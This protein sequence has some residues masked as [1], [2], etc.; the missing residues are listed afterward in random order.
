[1]EGVAFRVCEKCSR[2]TIAW[3]L[4]SRDTP[5]TKCSCCNLQ[6]E[7]TTDNNTSLQRYNLLVGYKEL[8][9]SRGRKIVNDRVEAQNL[10][11]SKPDLPKEIV[12]LAGG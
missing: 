6:I 10:L 3:E 1:M 5:A 11:E 4:I 12:F 2:V 8:L 7:E 9:N